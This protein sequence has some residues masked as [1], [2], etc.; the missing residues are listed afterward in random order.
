MRQRPDEAGPSR[1]PTP[2]ARPRDQVTESVIA[3]DE[4]SLDVAVHP[5]T[6]E[7][8]NS[9]QIYIQQ[10]ALEAKIASLGKI[11]KAHEKVMTRAPNPLGLTIR[12]EKKPAIVLFHVLSNTIEI[13]V[14]WPIS[15]AMKH[16]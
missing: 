15:L 9:E 6:G 12:R 13:P 1:P 16:Q 10:R 4:L 5:R 7:R 11:V 8:L 3:V 2:H 14:Q